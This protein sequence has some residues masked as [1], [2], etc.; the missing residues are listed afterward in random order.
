MGFKPSSAD[1]GVHFLDMESGRILLLVYVDDILIAAR[2]KAD[3]EWVK[4]ALTFKFE[5]HDLGEAHSFLGIDIVRDRAAG[6]VKRS[7]KGLTAELVEEN[8]MGDCKAKTVPM[9]TADKLTKSEG[10][11]LDKATH[12]CTNLIGSLLYLS[13]CTR[14]DIAQAVG[15]LSKFMKE[16]TSVHCSARHGRLPKDC[17]SIHICGIDTEAEHRVWEGAQHCDWI[18]RC[19]PRWSPGN[20]AVDDWLVFLVNGG[21]ITWLSKR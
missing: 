15:V 5:A 16:P 10:R 17:S 6:T 2:S 18:L 14:P 8:G 11:P 13:V 19:R 1:P 7:Q 12:T 20:K 3:V 4:Q 21:A 9:S